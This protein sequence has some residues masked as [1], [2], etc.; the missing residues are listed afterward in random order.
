MKEKKDIGNYYLGLDVGTNSLGW[1]ITDE[2]YKIIKYKGKELRGIRL[3]EEG[4]TAEERR[5]FRSNKRRLDRRKKRKKLLQDLF[6]EEIAK[7]DQGFYQR[8]N[9][10]NLY[11]EDKS[12]IQKNSLFNDEIITDKTYHE[13]F[14]TIY[15]LRK[16]IIDN[17]EKH[18]VRLVYLALH[19][20]LKNRGHFLFEGQNFDEVID[21]KATYY[22]VK[23]YYKDE[24]NKEFECKDLEKFQD[25][26]KN[27]KMGKRD[28]KNNIVK[29]FYECDKQKKGVIGL[30]CGGTEK[31]SDIF[32][33][34]EMNDNE[35][36]KITF[37]EGKYEENRENLLLDLGDNIVLLDKL[38]GMY[39]WSILTEI[40][41]G[42]D[43]ISYAKVDVYEKHKS[44][45]ALLKKVIKEF[46]ESEYKKI[47]SE[48]GKGI[49]N[50]P[51]YIKNNMKNNK[52]EYVEKK[53]TQEDFCK[54]IEKIL[55]SIKEKSREVDYLLEEAENRTLLPKQITKDNVVIPY[56]V[57]EKEL[58]TILNNSS[59]Y[60]GFLNTKDKDGLTI[61][62]KIIKIFEFR[63]PYYI[64]PV[65]DYHKKYGSNSWIVKRND[66]KIYPW[67]FENVVDIEASAEKFITRMTNKCTYLVG[68]DVLP[69]KSLLYSEFTVLNEIN[70]I[71]INRESISLEMKNSIYK[72][73]E[74]KKNITK[75][76]IHSYLLKEG[77]IDKEDELSGI[78]DRCTSSLTSYMDF[79]EIL[80]GKTR[81]INMIENIILWI[82]LYTDDKKILKSK[83]EREYGDKLSKEEI[84]R[85]VSL[86]Y[87]G[88]G[89]LS[90]K[91]LE[92][93]YHVNKSTGEYINIISSL[94]NTNL[95]LMKLLS[96][97]YNYLT[98]IANF[99]DNGETI[100]EITYDSLIK[101]I[102]TSPSVKRM[103]WQTLLVVTEVTKYVKSN[104]TKIFIEM[105]RGGEKN[106]KRTVSR[107]N[108]LI[109]LYKKCKEESRDWCKELEGKTDAELRG[110]KLYLYY[111]QKGRCMYSGESIKMEELFNQN[112][113]DIDHIF[114]RSKTKDDS[115]ENKVL[116]KRCEN[117]RKTDNYPIDINI[118]N[119]NIRFWKLLKEQGFISEKKYDR[120]TRNTEFS[121]EELADFIARQL[122]E[123]R[124]STKIIAD[125]LGKIYNESNIV[126]VKSGLVSDF[127][128]K[129]GLLKCRS[130]NDYH[131][132][133]D[134]YLNIV[135]GNIYN[136]KF[137]NNP[138]N[139]IKNR[140]GRGY[141]LATIFEKDVKIKENKI[142]DCSSNGTIITVK[143]V[144]NSN[145]ILFTRYSAEAKGQLFD[146]NIIGKLKCKDK[147]K[148]FPTKNGKNSKV[149]DVQKYGGYT[150]IKGAYFVLVEHE[151]KNKTIRT[152]E[153]IPAY[154]SKEID[155]NEKILYD[156][157]TNKLE[158]INPRVIISKIKMNSLLKIDGYPVH[159]TGRSGNTILAKTAVQLCLD[160]ES[161]NTI[162][163]IEKYFNRKKIE[164]ENINISDYK[165]ITTENNIR[166]Y[167]IYEKK[168][169]ET[170][171]KNR[172][173]SQKELMANGRDIFIK[174]DLEEQCY[175][176]N[177][178][179]KLMQCEKITADLT[180]IKGSKNG[181][182][183]SFGKNLSKYKEAKIIYQ[184]P[185]GLFK[186]EID[187]LK[188]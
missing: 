60:L 100:E 129:F 79:K 38:K 107:K 5:I 70:N 46:K 178:I 24:F 75:K 138:I 146:Q 25:I 185:A 48:N 102:I 110:E 111:T 31:L 112:I 49:N 35:I 19:N 149:L 54:Y 23:E 123:T 153:S 144:V 135:V 52:K 15:H 162:R 139:F 63:I 39:D 34:D 17:E 45:L 6:A 182:L 172:F 171:Y 143:K 22:Q 137:T 151:N 116:V 124:Q 156:Y 150:K 152:L 133:H 41:E 59:K 53:I 81:D 68:E 78:D 145:N 67:N 105:A 76:M 99:N 66:S 2:K 181:G 160:Q 7:I 91:F 83:I 120:L 177:E 14:P 13:K 77:Y 21:F 183:I 148:C 80:M 29:I 89:R 55:S 36:S 51:S 176:L 140:D 20:I 117:L 95:N 188:I 127:R 180:K 103:I 114:P 90:R 82:T 85:I 12:E 61:C 147:N 27:K 4:Q 167:D 1:A 109:D 94:R 131:H 128:H 106:K 73:F 121:D 158:L 65:N 3:F 118:Q 28:K 175:V 184:S 57:H 166:L 187:L 174:L 98:E 157:L 62:D 92:E 10:S 97:E 96:N 163:A 32:E 164:K 165:E 50:Y 186:K 26:L 43:Y 87:S 115:L 64:G 104:P 134:A 168:Q 58:K 108:T 44:D 125:L 154:L 37:S 72:L 132:A 74:S 169:R 159:I 16:S 18:D 136:A 9:D 84:K 8:M 56:Q 155:E 161:I 30:I 86:K 173:N 141:N 122:V 11:P 71:K 130:V 101:D 119:K 33:N 126:Y 113:Y 40:L 42:N 69:A 142:W 170:I 47:F 179:L 93:I 88:W